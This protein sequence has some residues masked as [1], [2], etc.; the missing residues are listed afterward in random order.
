MMILRY[1][2]SRISVFD[3]F[4]I[5]IDER[6]QPINCIH[7]L[8]TIII[9][10]SYTVEQNRGARDKYRIIYEKKKELLFF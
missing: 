5:V 10:S 6:R 1:V 9:T 4:Y 7:L 2:R 8:Y 3:F